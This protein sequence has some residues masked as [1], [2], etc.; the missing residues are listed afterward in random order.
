MDRQGPP[1]Q[2]HYQITRGLNRIRPEKDA[3]T[4]RCLDSKGST[5]RHLANAHSVTGPTGIIYRMSFSD[6]WW[7][8]LRRPVKQLSI[9]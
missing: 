6:V 1:I 5:M 8:W 9:G 4:S 2:P 7:D 3:M